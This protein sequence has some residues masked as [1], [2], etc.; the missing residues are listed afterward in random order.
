MRNPIETC[1]RFAEWPWDKGLYLNGPVGCGKTLLATCTIRGMILGAQ[2]V[3]WPVMDGQRVS[4]DDLGYGCS[5]LTFWYPEFRFVNVPRLLAEIKGTFSR[6]SRYELTTNDVIQDYEKCD[7]LVLDDLGAEKA[8]DWVREMMFLVVDS[9]YT[10]GRQTIFTSNLS[11][12]QLGETL[13]ERIAD[14][15]V[16]MC[17]GNIVEIRADSYRG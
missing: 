7:V 14:R 5:H 16:E 2:E 12:R 1:R 11:P 6:Q 3:G 8:T 9:R 17:R 10:S 4:W 15:I 13:S